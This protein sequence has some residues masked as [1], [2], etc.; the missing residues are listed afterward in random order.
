FSQAKLILDDAL[1]TWGKNNLDVRKEVVALLEDNG[2]HAAAAQMCRDIQ[3][4]LE[5]SRA[6]YERAV[7]SERAAEETER[8]AKTDAERAKARADRAEAQALKTKAQPLR[9][10]YWEFY[11][12]EGQA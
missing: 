8:K 2:S 6:E 9:E 12:S 4:S 7:Q 10:A 5:R 1:S 11:F 3:K